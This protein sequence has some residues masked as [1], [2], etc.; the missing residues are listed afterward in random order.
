[1]E[2][3]KVLVN[4]RWRAVP[5]STGRKSEMIVYQEKGKNKD[6]GLKKINVDEKGTEA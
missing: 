4:F 2:I 6:V 5:Y 1:M 3:I